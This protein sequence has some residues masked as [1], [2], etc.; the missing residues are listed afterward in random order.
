MRQGLI[1]RISSLLMAAVIILA[2]VY[3]P[4]C[5]ASAEVSWPSG[6]SVASPA[7]IVM[8]VET[9]VVLYSKNADEVHYPAS[10]T[11]IMTALLAV[12]NGDMSSTV[13]FSHD[14]V[15]NTE[16]SGIARDEGEEMTLEECL[17]GMMLE[18]ANECAYAIGE[19]IAGGSIDDFVDMMNAKAD[20]L[21]CKNTHFANSSGLP[22]ENHYTTCYDMALIA[23]EAIKNE[24]F[25]KITGTKSYSIPPTNKH[26]ESTPLNNHHAMLNY[27]KTSKYLYDYCIGGKTGY[28][29]AAQN[30]LVTY[31]RKDGMTLVCVVMN[32]SS[33]EHYTDTRALFD[34][35][36]ENFAVYNVAENME[37]FGSG[38]EEMFG[39]INADMNVLSID[40]DGT[41]V[42]P[43]GADLSEATISVTPSEDASINK[44]GEIDF[45]Y[46]D[47]Y[48]GG[49]NVLYNGSMSDYYALS[50]EQEG[51]PDSDAS[52]ADSG[53]TYVRLNPWKILKTVV[54][55]IVCILGIL[56]L[57]ANSGYII[58]AFNRA[59]GKDRQ[60]YKKIK[61]RKKRR[62]RRRR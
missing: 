15:Y 46:G 45:T 60:R 47:R 25:A 28:T 49:A 61:R 51:D 22:D 40:T 19:H 10:I 20:E 41:V 13:T 24:E 31:A 35:C 21:G 54:I 55:I 23:A 11:K 37:A 44:V 50:T 9:G 33:P 1:K 42:L 30:T 59:F 18:S 7:A 6:V 16:G 26:E 29:V 43:V 53:V 39:S 2:S 38:N 57:I 36:F 32:T 12:E 4:T 62:R 52:G 14:A 8:E 58:R 3:I 56:F 27:Y 34:Y 48:V 5:E 17:Y